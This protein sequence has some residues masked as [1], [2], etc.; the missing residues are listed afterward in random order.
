VARTPDLALKQKLLDDVVRYLATN[1]LANASLRPIAAAL[2]VS[3][4][5]LVHHFGTKDELVVAAL[6]RATHMQT[7]VQDGW[8]TREPHMSEATLLSKW[9]KW[10]VASDENLALVRLGLEAAALDATST[11][12]AGP[13]RAE[14]INVWRLNI[15][16]R[17]IAEGLSPETAEVEASLAKAMFTGLVVDLLATGDRKRLTTALDIGLDRLEKL[18]I[19]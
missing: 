2:G 12:I 13:V 9:W 17:L 14:Q 19:G 10:L 11:G 4:N 1:G 6:A 15:K 16:Q 8:L 5:A 18:V 7:A 3:V